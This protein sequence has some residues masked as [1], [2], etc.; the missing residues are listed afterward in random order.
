MKCQDETG[1]PF[2]QPAVW[3]F[4]RRFT[5]AT[6]AGDSFLLLMI[7]F[8][9]YDS[10][11]GVNDWLVLRD[12]PCPINCLMAE[13]VWLTVPGF[14]YT[15]VALL[16]TVVVGLISFCSICHPADDVFVVVTVVD[17]ELVNAFRQTFVFGWDS[18][19]SLHPTPL[20]L[21]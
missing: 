1:H 10:G 3:Y 8:E 13:F 14:R 7:Y 17:P 19:R 5:A 21:M 9:T 6:V 11:A 18:V 2:A 16:F 12:E 15:L 4:S 20:L